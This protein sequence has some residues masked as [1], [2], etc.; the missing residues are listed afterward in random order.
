VVLHNHNFQDN[1]DNRVE[2]FLVDDLLDDETHK[3]LLLLRIFQNVVEHL[4]VGLSYRFHVA[5][6]ST[7]RSSFDVFEQNKLL[8]T[9][10]NQIIF[11]VQKFQQKTK[12][13][14]P[15]TKTP[16]KNKTISFILNKRKVQ[17]K[18]E[19]PVVDW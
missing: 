4:I 15:K 18:L 12:S 16:R 9:K 3:V 11:K 8:F 1:N 17:F 13:N 14:K 5:E 7:E 10:K 6:P 2:I 19:C